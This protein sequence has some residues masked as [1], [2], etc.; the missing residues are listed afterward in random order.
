MDE[1]FAKVDRCLTMV[2]K[3]VL[4]R[5][6]RRAESPVEA[7]DQKVRAFA[8][9]ATRD[10]FAEAVSGL[11]SERS[12]ALAPLL[13]G[14]AP[15]LPRG[16]AF[17]PVAT[18]ATFLA[19]VAAFVWPVFLLVMVGLI[20]GNIALRLHLHQA[21]SI[22]ADALATIARLVGTA[23]KV[24][25]IGPADQARDWALRNDLEDVRIAFAAVAPWRK[26]LAWATLDSP[27]LNE[28]AA[29]VVAYLNVFFLL[30]V[31]A[32]VAS[33]QLLRVGTPALRTLFER[34]G[35]LD[36]ARSTASFREG[37]PSWCVPAL[38]RRG[39]PIVLTAMR[40]PMVEDA[41]PNDVLL[42][43]RGWLV[44][45]SNMSGKSTL[46]KGLAVQ[47]V[48]AQSIATATC[49]GY[50]APPLKVRT[51][52]HVEDDLARKK[53]HFHVEAEAV[54]DMLV[55]EC[56]DVDRLCVVDELFRGTNTHDRVAAGAAVLRG[57][58]RRGAFVVAA[59]HDAELLDLLE[60]EL[61]PHYFVE[62]VRNGA[63]VFDYKLRAGRAAP[64]NALAVLAMVG[65]PEDVLAD[66]RV[67]L[68]MA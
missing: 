12:G 24:G 15:A 50:A 59:T 25:A 63:L 54:K 49:E 14:D 27:R 35:E 48:L 53:S 9:P 29:A 33:L 47:A 39:S 34:I 31:N 60:A 43:H 65:C 5:R 16:A 10:Q 44:L 58:H 62:E 57:L 22:H 13:W 11:S 40:H 30:D 56:G 36:A 42:T 67:Y 1:V 61:D 45:G 28:V 37:N 52:I 19:G 38:G 4:Y 68:P 8:D 20:L 23:E 7:F 26:S 46:L 64:R 18:C 41:V 3:Q 55:E 51:L 2:G 32:Y 6:I 17:F 21:M 66:A